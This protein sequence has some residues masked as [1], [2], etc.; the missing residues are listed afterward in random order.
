[1]EPETQPACKLG[2]AECEC[3]N[4]VLARTPKLLELA[5]KCKD[6]GWDVSAAE[7]ALAEQLDMARKAKATFF[8]N[9]T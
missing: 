8:P 4:R 3:L 5:R 6:C 2:D 7:E 9:R 1:M